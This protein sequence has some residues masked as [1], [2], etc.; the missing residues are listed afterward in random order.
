M[1]AFYTQAKMGAEVTAMST[2]KNKE[3]EA[4]S[5]GAKHFVVEG[6]EE[7]KKMAGT[8]GK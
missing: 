5:F 7:A 4:K 8:Q 2:S 3:A 1:L 6:S